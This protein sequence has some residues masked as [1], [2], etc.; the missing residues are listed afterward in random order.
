MLLSSQSWD[1]IEINR[2]HTLVCRLPHHT[3]RA[4]KQRPVVST[5][6]NRVFEDL[7]G[8]RDRPRRPLTCCICLTQPLVGIRS[9][10]LV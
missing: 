6:R 9:R 8:Q 3:R 2:R 5:N 7:D 4:L 10:S 1:V